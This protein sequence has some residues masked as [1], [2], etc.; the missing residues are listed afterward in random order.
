MNWSFKYFFTEAI[1]NE[2]K[3]LEEDLKVSKENLSE[4]TEEIK[5]LFIKHSG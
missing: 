2:R 1:E 4:R 5:I 3:S